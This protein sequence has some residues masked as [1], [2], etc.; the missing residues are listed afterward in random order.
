MLF[1]H[2]FGDAFLDVIFRFFVENGRQ[3]GPIEITG[4]P[5][6]R[7]KKPPNKSLPNM[8]HL[9]HSVLHWVDSTLSPSLV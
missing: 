5:K 9:K 8:E 3:T 7:S 6:K 4:C 1:R 2:R